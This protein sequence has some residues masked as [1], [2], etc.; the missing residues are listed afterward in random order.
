MLCS[1]VTDMDRIEKSNLNRQFLFGYNDI[2]KFK[3][4]VLGRSVVNMNADVEVV[5]QLNRV[6]GE[7]IGLYNEEFFAGLDCVFGALD[8]VA[9]RLFVD[10][11]CLEHGKAYIDGGT[12]G[13]KGN[14]QVVVPGITKTYGST[15]DP[16]EEVVPMCTLKN[17]PYLIEHTI[18]WGLGLFEGW[19]CKA[20]RNY[21]RYV[22]NEFV[23]AQLGGPEF[24]EILDDILFVSANIPHTLDDCVKFGFKMWH[25]LYRDQIVAL[26]KK[27]PP[28]MKDEA[29]V[30]FW[31][32][33][34][35]CPSVREFGEDSDIMFVKTCATLWAQ[36]FGL[37]KIC[38]IDVSLMVVPP[39]DLDED[40]D[41]D[42]DADEDADEVEVDLINLYRSMLPPITDEMMK[43]K[44]HPLE[45]EKDDDTNFHVDFVTCA[46][47]LRARTYGIEE[48]DKFK[49]K[50]IAGKIIPAL[51]TTTSLVCGLMAIEFMKVLMGK[52]FQNSFLNLALP[53]LAMTEPEG[54]KKYRVGAYEFSMWDNLVVRGDPTLGTVVGEAEKRIANDDITLCSVGCGKYTLLRPMSDQKQKIKMETRISTLLQ[55]LGAPLISPMILLLGFENDEDEDEDDD[56]EPISCKVYL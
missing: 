3:A 42:G 18:Q 7:T 40:V 22:G 11:L 16:H 46:S 38:D 41:G 12:L 13:T 29:G 35:R 1:V 30:P 32:G 43:F 28:D 21:G 26:L 39:M 36:V 4:E 52:D 17:F 2:G 47:N 50:G 48:V 51:A 25:E 27:H 56:L 15:N 23:M 24:K 9:A 6:G 37:G 45:F 8:N 19:F 20:V 55:N 14:V 53:F 31:S 33:T 44:V 10:N 54:V 49:T 5:V 34:K